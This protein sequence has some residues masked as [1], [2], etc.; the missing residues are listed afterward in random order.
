MA[1]ACAYV[2]APAPGTFR[3][4]LTFVGKVRVCLNGKS[5]PEMGGAR[6]KLDLVKGWNRILLKVSPGSKEATGVADWYAVPVLHAFAPCEYRR[7]N[8]AWC[9]ALPGVATGFLRRRNGR[10]RAIIVGDRLYVASEGH[11]LICIRKA[12][13]KVLWLRRASAFEA[14]SEEEKKT[15]AYQQAEAIAAKLDAVNARFLAGAA[16]D[17]QFH[18]KKGELEK[19]LAKQMNA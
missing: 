19:A 11:D 9:T 15:P 10:C 18:E 14:A 1:Y 16:L 17:W 5:A 3:M 6:S 8:I 2:Y 12:D 7:S 13:G 4:N